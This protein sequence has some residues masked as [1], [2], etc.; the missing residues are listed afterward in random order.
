MAF[1][2]EL[3]FLL[4]EEEVP[5]VKR[6]LADLAK[7]SPDPLPLVNRYFDTAD[8]R[9]QSQKVA[10][11]I[12]QKK[13]QYLQT[14]KTKGE[15][16]GGL[17]KR[18]EWEWPIESL[19]LN[20][21]LL[22]ETGHFPSNVDIATLTPL[23]ETNFDRYAYDICRDGVAMEVVVDCGKVI[24]NDKSA[25]LFEVEIELRQEGEASDQAV[26]SLFSMA[27]SLADVATLFPSD[28]SK[29]ER[30]YYLAGCYPLDIIPVPGG[31]LSSKS[32]LQE[33]YRDWIKSHDYYALTGDSSYQSMMAKYQQE[34]ISAVGFIPETNLAQK[35]TI[36][37]H[38]EGGN[39]G[40]AAIQLMAHFSR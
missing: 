29:G 5:A 31:T 24:A 6:Y 1:E 8:L 38:L 9:L 33:L 12:R 26:Q 27:E 17:H 22:D 3:K 15:S 35:K 32:S 18:L 2:V 36:V 19:E 20:K 37:Q 14:F 40:I 11:R 7:Q 23:F 30:G 34:L 10:L 28:V 21:A 13:N 16:E 25:P 39:S 4:P